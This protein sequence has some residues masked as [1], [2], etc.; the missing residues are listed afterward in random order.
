MRQPERPADQRRRDCLD[1]SGSAGLPPQRVDRDESPDP[2]A[3]QA[4]AAD[5]VEWPDRSWAPASTR[6]IV[7]MGPDAAQYLTGQQWLACAIL[8]V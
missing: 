7:L 8:P 3:Y 1:H 6:N 5:Y 4:A 2:R